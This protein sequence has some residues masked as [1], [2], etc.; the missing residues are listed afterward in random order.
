[1]SQS[2]LTQAEGGWHGGLGHAFPLQ[3]GGERQKPLKKQKK[4]L[5]K[6]EVPPLM[7]ETVEEKGG[8]GG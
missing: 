7:V 8:K 6:L 2:S 4:K 5:G 1:M 3:P